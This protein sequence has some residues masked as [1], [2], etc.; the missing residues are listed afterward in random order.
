MSLEIFASIDLNQ[1]E[2]QNA[3]FPGLAAAPSSPVTGQFYYDTVSNTPFMWNGSAWV[4]LF[5]GT[6]KF[7]ATIGN[8]IALSFVV[9]HNLGTKDTIESVYDLTTGNEVV[10]IV[11]HTS[12]NTTTF[13]FSVPPALSNIRV[14]IHA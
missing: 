12:T 11:N 13:T 10:A 5:Q 2:I 4:S 8:G 1:N 9:T 14:V 3:A 7:A 6:S